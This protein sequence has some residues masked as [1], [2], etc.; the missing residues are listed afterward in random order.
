MPSRELQS[1]RLE[2]E[3][4]RQRNALLEAELT[5]RTRQ[6]PDLFRFLFDT[7]DEGFCVI[8]FF[9]GPHGPLSDYLHILANAAYARHAGIPNVV[10]Q[11]LREMV[12]DEADDWIARYGQVLRT[13]EPL[14]FEQELV[15]TGRVLSVTTFR[16]EPAEKNQVA[17]LFKDVTERR[18]AENA[19]QELN[20]HLE[21]RVAAALAE[22]SLLAEL[23]E[24]SVARV[25]VVDT[26]LRFLAVNARAVKDFE[27]L[28]GRKIKAGDNLH[29][30]L[31]GFPEERERSVAYW[32]R[33]LSGESY[34]E[35]I[36]YGRGSDKRHFELRFTPLRDSA[37]GIVGAYLFVYDITRQ[38]GEQK[39]LLETE[40]ALR[41]IQKMEAVGQLTGG[42]AH[43]FNNLLGGILGAQ[44]LIRQRLQKARY[45]DVPPLLNSACESAHRAATLVQRLLAFSRRQTLLPQATR[46]STLV[47]G[48]EDLI[49]RS[50]GPAIEVNSH[51]ELETGTVFIDPPQLESALLNLCINARDAM[52]AGGRIDLHCVALE[53]M[54][55]TAQSLDLPPGPYLRLSVSD[56]GRGMP[57]EVLDRAVEPF[58]TTKPMGQSTGLGLSMV[59]G[60]VRQSGG[61]LQICSLPGEGTCIHLYLPRHDAAPLPAPAKGMSLQAAH[62]PGKRVLLVEDQA[63]LRLV[64]A[65][66]LEELGHQVDGYATG[67]AALE[68][69][70]EFDLLIT[71]I[72]LPGGMNGRQVAQAMRG[73]LPSIPVL[74]ITG[75]DANAVLED[76]P[77]P[78]GMRVLTKPFDLE[79]LV[80]QVDLLLRD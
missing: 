75:Y 23:V 73:R 45:A 77:L 12:P 35:V 5:D 40:E 53:V 72:G 80:D 16:I 46:L 6:D 69:D 78:Q 29:E 4:L 25:Q 48:M 8:E 34:T 64:I 44:E 66:V 70:L 57:A 33:A 61:Q 43:D 28:F 47:Q 38:V 30:C 13:G 39:R 65:E 68:A 19:L 3:R 58:F 21:Q 2:V 26:S 10:G 31:D 56:T 79:K 71:D 7:M 55:D 20:D 50:V 59:Y 62:G 36:E 76:G 18:R 54:Q 63:A 67:P 15:A 27:Y 60:F 17:V 14:Q 11:K 49:S 37:G 32:R 1:L 24:N 22:R 42:I 74:F 51:F 41:Q 52:P 9:D